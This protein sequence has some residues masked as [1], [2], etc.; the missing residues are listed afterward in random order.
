MI[1]RRKFLQA[2]TGAAFSA[3]ALAAFPPSIRRALAIPANNATGTIMDVRHVVILMQENRSFDHYFGTLAGVRGFGD[4]LTI[5]LPN[6]RNVWQQARANGSI[7]T[8]YH[9]NGS[10]NNAQRTAGTPHAWADSQAAWDH[11]RMSRWPVAKTDTSM[12]YFKEQEIPFQFALAKAFTLCDAYH[13]AMHTGTDANRSF[14]MTG[15]NGVIPQ[16]VAFVNNEWDA[17]NGVAADANTGYTWKTYAERLEEA[18]ISW[19]SYQNMPDEWGDNML[20]AFQ[21]FRRANLNSGFPVSSGGAPQSPYTSTGQALPYHAY[22]AASDNAANPLYKGVAN[23]L[24]GTQPDQY[25]DAFKRDIANGTLPHVSWINAPS[26]YCEHPGPSSPV[27]G[28]WFLQEVLDALTSNPDV[29]SKTVLLV[30]FDENDGYFDHVPSPSAPSRHP[31]SSLAGKTTLPD[32]DLAAEYYTQ[33]PPAGSTSQPARDGRVFGPGPRVPMFVISPWSRGGWI[34]SQVFDHTSV[35]RFLEARF[36]VQESNISPFRRAVCGDLTTA[37]NF[38]TPNTEALPTLAGRGTRTS[39]DQLRTAQQ[40]LPAVP[41]PTTAQLPQQDTGSR[42]SRA[43]PYELHTSARGNVNGT[44]QL[45]FANSGKQAAVFHVYDRNDLD[46]VPRRYMVEAGKTLS[47]TWA[48]SSADAGQ[49]DLWVLGPNGY[50]RHFRGDTK[51]LDAARANPEI[52]VCYEVANGDVYVDLINMGNAPCTFRVT[53]LAYRTDGPWEASVPAGGTQTLH[54]ALKD[55]GNW[56]DFAVTS[57]SDATF[58]R[59]FAGRVETGSHSVT[60]PAMGM[61]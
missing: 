35:L 38:Q 6:G 27:Q 50:H 4:R 26:I 1:S 59:R 13:C 40:A 28:A 54:W 15:T 21:S 44:V 31:D 41:V 16:N 36:G 45:L 52:R 7:V 53:P 56:Y 48:T 32:A 33:Q 49:Y 43:L 2:S 42:P 39:A 5:P 11:G 8:P 18:G 29:W 10:A 34:N 57:S 47:D 55:S 20:G 61:L 30:N 14:H 19:I 9:L 46:S 22:D 17:I 24:P 60:D 51:V 12:G 23:T 58:Y 37:F 25:L 3:A